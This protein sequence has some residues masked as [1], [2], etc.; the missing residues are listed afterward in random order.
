[1]KLNP[2]HTATHRYDEIQ[3][4]SAIVNRELHMYLG[5]A[6]L[7][8]EFAITKTH[9]SGLERYKSWHSL[10]WGVR[11][12]RYYYGSYIVSLELTLL[13]ILSGIQL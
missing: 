1:M 11:K 12:P 10:Q 9:C 3:G 13:V 7:L 6:E 5:L 2:L 4:I 8:Y